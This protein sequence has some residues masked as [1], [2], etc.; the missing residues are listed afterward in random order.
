MLGSSVIVVSMIMILGM[1][2]VAS[3]TGTWTEQVSNSPELLMVVH[4]VTS[5]VAWAVGNAGQVVVTV[6]GGSHWVSRPVPGAIGLR[7]LF[8]FDDQVCVVSDQMGRFWRTTNGGLQWNQVYGGTGMSINGI[9]FFDAQNGWAVGDPVGGKFVILETTDGGLTW[10]SS[11]NAPPA[12]FN[13]NGWTRSFDWVGTEIGAFGTSKWVIWRTTNGGAQWDSVRTN[14]EYVYG[15]VLADNGIGLAG[16]HDGGSEAELDRSTDFGHSWS[17]IQPPPQASSLKTFD[18]ID[19]TSEVWGVTTQ[20]GVFHSTNGGL[21]WVRHVLAPPLD[22]VEEDVDFVD[23]NTGW[24][25]GWRGNDTG[26]I[27]KYSSTTGITNTQSAPVPLRVS[28]R[29]NPFETEVAFAFEMGRES[30][31]EIT[32]YDV[33]GQSMCR[34]VAR[35]G[36]YRWDG[37]DPAGRTVASG[38][39]LYRLKSATSEFTGRMIKIR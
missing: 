23:G 36:E 14:S 24:C 9:H 12:G 8:G 27:F 20:T 4:A 13:M 29:P 5:E 22:F 28:I 10:I 2:H 31:V 39:Y 7:G 17:A 32:I 6:D 30:P 26:R 15:L 37:L 11:P 33:T 25:V 21:D 19:G 38:M 1:P 35:S 18:W 16:G 3:A 34:A